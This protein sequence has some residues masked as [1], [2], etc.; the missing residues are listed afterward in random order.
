MGSRRGQP[1]RRAVI[2]AIAGAAAAA[3]LPRSTRAD[4][5]AGAKATKAPVPVPSMTT[6]SH[7][8]KILG[9]HCS[10]L[11]PPLASPVIRKVSMQVSV[12]TTEP[13]AVKVVAWPAG[14]P[15]QTTS[16]LWVATKVG[17]DPT[18]PVNVAK[19]FMPAGTGAPGT[20]WQ[21]RA[22][23]ALAGTSPTAPQSA[24]YGTDGVV[25]AIPLRPADGTAGLTTIVAS[26]CSEVP[27]PT[28]LA[29]V[30]KAAQSM[31]AVN[32]AMFVHMGDTSYVDTWDNYAQDTAAHTYTKY[33]LGYRRHLLEPEFAALYNAM[34]MRVVMDD[35]DTGPDNDYETTV[36]PQARQVLTDIAAGTT[37]DNASYDPTRPG[38]PTYDTWMMGQ[39][40]CWLLDNR[41]WRDVP[42]SQ[43]QSYLHMP[44]SSQM[45]ATQRTWLKASLAASK[46]PVKIIFTPR[47][48]TQFYEGGE[49]MEIVDWITGYQSGVANVS[50]KVAFISGDMHAAAVW[51]LSATRPVYEM[52][53]GPILNSTLHTIKPLQSWQEDWGYATLFCNTAN[54]QPGKATSFAWGRIDVTLNNLVTLRVVR[55]DGT[56]LYSVSF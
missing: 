28:Q 41:L 5:S 42:G 39:A 9:A 43:P 11:G 56:V 25:R 30:F 36:Y 10:V 51:R 38:A 8:P 3:V 53:C 27:S 35:H 19:F 31:V 7:A 34:P 46:A 33:A 14:Q 48:F 16:S 29:R 26:S 49:Q 32:P 22:Y 37:F 17:T 50:G 18:N 6:T 13:A 4:A 52:L 24:A 2:G 55:D 15:T 54:G 23:V 1:S 44:Y 40:Q 20:A 21:W 12:I 45:G 47:T